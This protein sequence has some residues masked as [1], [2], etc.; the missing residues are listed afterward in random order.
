MHST[1]GKLESAARGSPL[2]YGVNLR[3]LGRFVGAAQWVC[4]VSELGK[5][6]LNLIQGSVNQA[7]FAMAVGTHFYRH[8][9]A[10]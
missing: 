5:C 9:K 1:H 3:M 6:R 8:C 4:K 10:Q 2:S 7:S